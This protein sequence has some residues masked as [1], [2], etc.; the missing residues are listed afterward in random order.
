M[1]EDIIPG[2]P[3]QP[4][5]P[6]TQTPSNLYGVN[7]NL[8]RNLLTPFEVTLRWT[9]GILIILLTQAVFFG[10]MV[11][12]VY[13]SGITEPIARGLLGLAADVALVVFFVVVLE[14]RNWLSRLFGFPP[15][16]REQ[17]I[18]R[19][20]VFSL[21][22]PFALLLVAPP[23]HAPAAE[24]HAPAPP[25]PVDSTREVIETVVFVVVLVLLLKS[26]VAEAFV[27][28]TGSMA[29]TLWGNQKVI[30]C[31]E[32][33]YQFP[34]NCSREVEDQDGIGPQRTTSCVCPNCRLNIHLINPTLAANPRAPDQ[35][36]DPGPT[37]GDRVLVAKFLYDLFAK[38]PDRLDVVVFKFPGNSN[39]SEVN[40]QSPL[41]PRSGP[42]KNQI[43]MN[44]I[45]RLIGLP[46]E[47]IAIQGGKL[48]V[49]IP[50][51]S[52]KYDDLAQARTPAERQILEQQ[53]WHYQYM[54]N[55][56]P[57]AHRLWDEHKFKILRKGPENVL[58]MKRIVYDNDHQAKDLK[59]KLPPRWSGDGWKEDQATGLKFAG[60]EA[61]KLSWLRYHHY[62][63]DRVRDGK[64]VAELITDFMGYNTENG[65]QMQG[66][67]WV[68]DLVLECEVTID[69]PQGELVLE[70]SRGVDR[71]QAQLNL[72]DGQCK[73]VRVTT[74]EDG[75]PKTSEL[76]STKTN[77]GKGT[78]RLRF[79][80]VDE[81]LLLWINDKLVVFPQDV[82]F[83][84]PQQVGPTERN[85]LQPASV[86]IKGTSAH[87]QHL[88]LWRDTYY[89]TGR[90]EVSGFSPSNPDTWKDF[91]DMPVRTMYVQPDHFLCL[92]DNSS[93]SAD[94]RSWGV[95]PRRLMLGK[96]L[97]VYYPFY[98]PFWPLSSQVNRVELIH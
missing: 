27:I 76:S 74:G 87:V 6:A 17:A 21:I 71:F 61:D 98:F 94:S 89:T 40:S 8:V 82:V 10:S 13:V 50:E 7:P 32:C 72:A 28:P 42:F 14:H 30:D 58:A 73:M 31:P 39:P 86:G 12:F 41:F 9:L 81:R 43:P 91:K 80:D 70:L 54:H 51:L 45:K 4:A 92:G 5:S 20:I 26:F 3:E 57:K 53:L 44:Y 24:T 96:A 97:A 75:K 23:S 64:P 34:V 38:D 66:S 46:G 49:L 85:D 65:G 83:D 67:N 1:P 18:R 48:Y 88:K 60:G 68:R 16:A 15:P 79:S 63:R 33:G 2:G 59:T 62:L 19:A 84:P 29:E 52:P 56:D 55:D 69:K 77:L 90:G 25:Q 95:V 47:T 93:H 37:S 78:Y 36:P 22:G 11:L 35:I